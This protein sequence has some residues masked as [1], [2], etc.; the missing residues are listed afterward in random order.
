VEYI[1]IAPSMRLN[2][3]LF[4][5]VQMKRL[6]KTNKIYVLMVV[7]ENDVETYDAFEDVILLVRKN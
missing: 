1:V 4:S 7:R 2:T 5:A 3:T 6:I